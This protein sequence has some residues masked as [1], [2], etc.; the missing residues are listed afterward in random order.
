MS[1]VGFVFSASILIFLFLSTKCYSQNN[2]G[3]KGQGGII[4]YVDDYRKHGLAI[5]T[6]EL[7]PSDWDK[8]MTDCTNLTRNG[9]SDWRL[10]NKIEMELLYLTRRYVPGISNDYY[11]T[12]TEYSRNDAHMIQFTTGVFGINN[13]KDGI[14][15]VRAVRAF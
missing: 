1:K 10:P 12:S 15:R 11:W 9:Y 5:D 3:L 14:Y 6:I 7:E 13:K 2:P 4:F 8:A